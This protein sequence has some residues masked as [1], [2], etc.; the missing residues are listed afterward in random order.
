MRRDIEDGQVIEIKSWFLVYEVM[1]YE[2]ATF[3]CR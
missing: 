1:K 2:M 3:G